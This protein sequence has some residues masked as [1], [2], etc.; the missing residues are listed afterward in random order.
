MNYSSE[1]SGPTNRIE[2]ITQAIVP[3]D[4]SAT[5]QS[6]LTPVDQ[7]RDMIVGHMLNDYNNSTS[8]AVQN[9]GDVDSANMMK[10]Y[11]KDAESKNMV[12]QTGVEK[13]K[14][15]LKT[16]KQNLNVELAKQ[17]IVFEIL[18]ILG[19]TIVVYIVLGSSPYVHGVALAVLVLGILYVLNY[20][21]YRLK[22]IG[23]D[24]GSP[25][26]SSLSTVFTPPNTSAWPS[27]FSP[28]NAP[29]P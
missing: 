29:M 10:H 22:A 7:Q 1:I 11:L 17:K 18:G 28:P 25:I 26:L 21:A 3:T 5:I 23:L 16:S 24:I 13:A 19:V 6:S 14:N 27:L 15:D 9:K 20:N 8:R 12:I 2:S 4:T